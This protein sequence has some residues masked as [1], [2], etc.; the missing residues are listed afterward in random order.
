MFINC[1][2]CSALV[3]TNLATGLPPQRCPRCGFGPLAPEAAAMTAATASP[4]TPEP[5]SERLQPD[6]VVFIPLS[7]SRPAPEPES[8]T[9]T[10]PE[11]ESVPKPVPETEPALAPE[12][13]PQPGPAVP[14]P[15]ADTVAA[16]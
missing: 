11:P 15:P 16:S 7:P 9:E 3:A 5:G 6:K 2:D 10:D 12:P 14:E 13:P 8:K 4:V 1:P